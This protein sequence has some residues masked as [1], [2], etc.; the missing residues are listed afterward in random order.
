MAR[1]EI[2]RAVIDDLDRVMLHLAAHDSRDVRQRAAEILNAIDALAYN[3]LM[4]R[5]VESGKRELIIG[6]DSRGYVALYRFVAELDIVF[7][8]AIRA[9]REGGYADA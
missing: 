8:L 5:L 6:S 7:V 2:A 1:V 4:G 9:Q 3:P